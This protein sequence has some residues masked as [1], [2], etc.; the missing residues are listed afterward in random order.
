MHTIEKCLTLD[1]N[2]IKLEALE[3]KYIALSTE[4]GQA[5]IN[6]CK[7]PDNK[8]I[9]ESE[10]LTSAVVTMFFSPNVELLASAITSNIYVLDTT[11]SNIEDNATS[12][13][14]RESGKNWISRLTWNVQ[15]D[16]RD[17]QTNPYKGQRFELNSM[18]NSEDLGS[19]KILL[20]CFSCSSSDK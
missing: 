1:S 8:L 6:S 13:L 19:S 15:Y 2:I 7:N 16:T 12:A 10:K 14:T 3:N 17:S 20:R 4:D 5:I 9:I 18:F 11:I